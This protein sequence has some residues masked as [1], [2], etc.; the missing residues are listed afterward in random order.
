M[1]QFGTPPCYGVIQ[2]IGYLPTN[3]CV[4][5]GVKMVSNVIVWHYNQLWYWDSDNN[6]PRCYSSTILQFPSCALA[7]K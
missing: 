1:V 4:M 2:W 7:F 6:H 3:Y 5:A